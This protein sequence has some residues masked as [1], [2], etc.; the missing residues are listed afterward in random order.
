[1]TLGMC[2]CQVG[3]YF[4]T[5]LAVYSTP[6]AIGSFLHARQESMSHSSLPLYTSSNPVTFFIFSSISSLSPFHAL[7]PIRKCFTSSTS[8]LLHSVHFFSLF[9][10]LYLP[11]STCICTPL[12]FVSILLVFFLLTPT[13]LAL[14]SPLTS[15]GIIIIHNNNNHNNNIWM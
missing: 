5:N 14:N 3:L 11:T 2:M 12:R 7:H 10:P 4:C 15:S 6:L 1:M 13:H 8:P 9:K